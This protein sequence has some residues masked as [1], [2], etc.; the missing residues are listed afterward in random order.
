VAAAARTIRRTAIA[1]VHVTAHPLQ[2]EAPVAVEAV[3]KGSIAMQLDDIF[4][5]NSR[6]LVQ[7]VDILGDHGRNFARVIKL[8]DGA[9][10]A[11]G[12]SGG[13]LLFHGKAPPPG[14]VTRFLA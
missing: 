2:F 14:L 7:I 1:R 6:G 8:G 5:R 3:R 11:A 13:K 12:S 10:A 9:M 4:C